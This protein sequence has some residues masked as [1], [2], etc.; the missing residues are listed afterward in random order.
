LIIKDLRGLPLPPRKRLIIRH[1]RQFKLFSHCLAS[2]LVKFVARKDIPLRNLGLRFAS[3][4]H[5]SQHSQLIKRQ[6]QFDIIHTRIWYQKNFICQQKK[7]PS[8]CSDSHW[9]FASLCRLRLAVSVWVSL[10]F[11]RPPPRTWGEGPVR[12]N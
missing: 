7:E 6:A 9:G 12:F 10:P 5:A 3:S 8:N 2:A 1:L 4:H 11:I